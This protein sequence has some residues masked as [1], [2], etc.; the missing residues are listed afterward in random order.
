MEVDLY[1]P[2]NVIYTD[3]NS[4]RTSNGT[5]SQIIAGNTTQDGYQEGTASAARFRLIQGFTQISSTQIVV[6]DTYNYCLRL[7]DRASSKTTKLAGQC[8]KPRYLFDHPRSV[9]KDVKKLDQLIVAYGSN[10][11]L[12]SVDVKTGDVNTLIKAFSFDSISQDE[13]SGDLFLTDLL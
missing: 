2:G 12:R 5:V 6:S 10:R 3:R 13:H 4:I 8:T 11:G 9:I 7:V 1:I